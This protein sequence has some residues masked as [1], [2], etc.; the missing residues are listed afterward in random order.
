MPSKALEWNIWY[1]QHI[2]YVFMLLTSQSPDYL[3]PVHNK[4]TWVFI[5]KCAAK[6]SNITTFSLWTHKTT[7]QTQFIS[8]IYTLVFFNRPIFWSYT[9]PQNKIF[10]TVVEGFPQVRYP[11]RHAISSLCKIHFTKFYTSAMRIFY[12]QHSIFAFK[13]IHWLQRRI[14]MFQSINQS[15]IN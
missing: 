6:S 9:A 3:L 8:H 10:T 5:L 4:L 2:A 14:K 11:S 13:S 7:S 15:L 1:I 12:F